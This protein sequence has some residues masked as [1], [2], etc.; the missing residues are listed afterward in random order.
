MSTNYARIFQ[1]L[2]FI[3]LLLPSLASSVVLADVEN[4]HTN[5][6]VQLDLLVAVIPHVIR[7]GEEIIIEDV[8]MEKVMF[9]MEKARLFYFRNSGCKL[10][11]NYRY[12][13]IND[14]IEFSGWWLPPDQVYS[15]LT[16]WLLNTTGGT[17]YDFDGVIALWADKGYN[18]NRIDQTGA[19]YGPG[20]TVYR[21][22][23]F[24]LTVAIA[25]VM[26]HEFHHQL[27]EF[28]DR[29]GYPEYRFCHPR[30]G[31]VEDPGVYGEH[32]DVNA[33][34]MRIW[35]E[36]K[37]LSLKDPNPEILC[38]VDNDRDGFPD[39][40][41]NLPMDE[42]RFGSDP[43]KIDTDG[44]GLT[45]LQEFMAGIY[46]GSDPKNPDTD[47]DGLLDGEDPYPL[48][49]LNTSVEFYGNI[50]ALKGVGPLSPL[51]I[52]YS[53]PDM[54]ECIES[55]RQKWN[56]SLYATWN[57]TFLTIGIRSPEAC[58]V[59]LY[60][61]VNGDGWFHGRDNVEILISPI[62]LAHGIPENARL[63]DCTLPKDAPY[64]VM[65]EDDPKYPG[66]RTLFKRD[67]KLTFRRYNESYNVIVYAPWSKIGGFPYLYKKVGIRVVFYR[68]GEPRWISVFEPWTFVYLQLRKGD[69]EKEINLIKE[70]SL[71]IN[72]EK[73]ELTKDESLTIEGSVSPKI[74]Y[75]EIDFYYSENG[76]NWS[77]LGSTYTRENGSFNFK[78]S[79][80][81]TGLWIV[82]C[83]LNQ[84]GLFATSNSLQ[85]E[86][87]E[88]ASLWNFMLFILIILFLL[89][90]FLPYRKYKDKIK[91]F[92]T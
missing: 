6:Y 80:S 71:N 2:L 51:L 14:T 84:S 23:S 25:W 4:S 89:I 67:I 65:W 10:N 30:E 42:A 52:N 64:P 18:P 45:D 34:I 9:E 92:Y 39:E 31:W 81:E 40:D 57:E 28:F 19:V 35:P 38:F 76:S 8:G 75:L 5:K 49:P 86:V 37:W 54:W 20:G 32:Y 7:N 43:A 17:I 13:I 24:S 48:Y 41:S 33:Y 66:K 27:D 61:D 85:I 16:K 87:K 1:P 82:Q 53:F 63:F 11:L 36:D 15:S 78:L 91:Y 83:R 12:V 88:P 70:V 22:S 55:Y 46:M 56:V 74:P 3:F 69:T 77:Y 29:S 68:N 79:L 47:G 44:D 73:K 21:Y 58:K 90:I 72:C 60:L 50:P 59:G 26:T 62:S